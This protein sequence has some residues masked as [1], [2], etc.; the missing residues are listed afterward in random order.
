MSLR[1]DSH[2]DHQHR[3]P[4]VAVPDQVQEVL[5]VGGGDVQRVDHIEEGLEESGEGSVSTSTPWR[6]G[7]RLY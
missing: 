7:L 1:R 4:P 6:A 5:G 2:V 3:L